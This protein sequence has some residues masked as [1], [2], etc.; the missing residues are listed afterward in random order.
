MAGAM[1]DRTRI[2]LLFTMIQEM[3]VQLEAKPIESSF[4][5]REKTSHPISPVSS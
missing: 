5:K 3:Q 2:A 4:R 1:L